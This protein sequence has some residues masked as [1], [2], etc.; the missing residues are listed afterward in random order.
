[1]LRG[2]YIFL[3]LFSSAIAFYDT[4]VIVTSLLMTGLPI[5]FKNSFGI[6]KVFNILW[7]IQQI[8]WTTSI[9]LITLLTIQRYVSVF[10]G[11]IPS[12]TKTI[13]SIISVILFGVVYNIPRFFEYNTES[14]I[15]GMIVVEN[16]EYGLLSNE[17]YITGYLIW[18]NFVFR[19]I[20]PLSIIT[21]CNIRFT[22]KVRNT[23]F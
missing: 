11:R 14:H 4:V 9:Y 13:V 10:Q 2:Y 16:K 7:P 6:A 5:I 21:F 3:F 18:S 17:T 20:L 19:L 12:F 23:L 1:M 15:N 22:R 8:A